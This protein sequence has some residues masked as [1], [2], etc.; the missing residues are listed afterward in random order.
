MEKLSGLA[1]RVVIGGPPC[2]GFSRAG[3]MDPL[4]PRS[5]H[6]RRFID[7]V[8]YMQPEAFVMENV[9][10]LAD[11]DRWRP[12]LESARRRARSHGY[13]TVLVR[14]NAADFGVPQ[15][16]ERMFL[17]GLRRD[18]KGRVSPSN[19][20]V[21]ARRISVRDT[22]T[23]SMSNGADPLSTSGTAAIIL[24]RRPVVRTSPY[25]GMLFNGQGRPVNLEAPALTIPASIGGNHT[26]IIDQRWLDDES[27]FG[28]VEAFHARVAN[29]ERPAIPDGWRRLSA[30]EAAALQGFPSDYPWSG[31]A[32]AVYRQI[33]NA[34]PP[35]LATEV[36]RRL[37]EW[38]P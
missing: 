21:H 32:N 10:S 20:T 4:D 15:T 33:G 24:A 16:R 25:A 11:S 27:A 13:R 26:P 38:L 30:R 19:G 37:R 14:L 18:L 5:M 3:L 9:K 2:Q 28:R 17:F 35:P 22:L 36:G 31:P 1:P 34:V 12:V 6:V 29:G 8:G 7:S 23:P